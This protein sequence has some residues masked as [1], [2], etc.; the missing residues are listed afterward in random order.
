[1]E[2][3]E[4]V[5]VLLKSYHSVFVFLFQGYT[6]LVN[7]S[8]CQCSCVTCETN[9]FRCSNG[10]CIDASARCDGVIDCH[11]DEIGCGESQFLTVVK[12]IKVTMTIHC[13]HFC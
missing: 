7:E 5:N 10:Q 1:M 8:S 4:S 11:D 13:N 9:E 6:K 12:I 2:T 3:V